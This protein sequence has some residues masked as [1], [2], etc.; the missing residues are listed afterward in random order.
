MLRDRA[1]LDS[2]TLV[3]AAQAVIDGPALPAGA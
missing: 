3:E 2:S 1:M